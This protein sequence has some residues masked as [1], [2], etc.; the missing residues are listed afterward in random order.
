[1][2]AGLAPS[3]PPSA[4]APLDIRLAWCWTEP[5]GD[6]AAMAKA[7]ADLGFNALVPA[8][9]GKE[10]AY[11]AA[12]RERGLACY[13]PIYADLDH[14]GGDGPAQ[15]MLSEEEQALRQQQADPQKRAAYQFGGQ[16]TRSDEIYWNRMLCPN[17]PR[18]LRIVQRQIDR[19]LEA[20]F[21]GLAFDYFGYQNYRRCYCTVCKEKYAAFISALPGDSRQGTEARFAEDSLVRL[22]NDAVS[23]ARKQHPRVLTTAHI[24]PHFAPNS[25]YGNRL[26]LDSCGVTA[27][28]FFRPHWSLDQVR[29]YTMQVM[30]GANRH[31]PRAVGCPFIGI[32]TGA[33]H[34]AERKDAGRLREELGIVH[35]AG[36]K[37]IQMAELGHI[38]ADAETRAVVHDFLHPE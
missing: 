12:C 35:A 26:D 4:A 8:L 11:L 18:T 6:A 34:A 19:A 15:V 33:P 23:Y 37:G 14:T 29:N 30:S 3:V 24:Y 10:K 22:I 2:L 13:M 27:S 16:P 20:G 25:L 21:D 9:P 38:L 5:L 28:W 7:A 36:A 31:F 32:Y 17:D 1:M